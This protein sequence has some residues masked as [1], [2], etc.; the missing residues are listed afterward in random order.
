MYGASYDLT[1]PLSERNFVFNRVFVLGQD[2]RWRTIAQIKTT[3]WVM[4][5]GLLRGS[6]FLAATPML[7]L[8]M[9]SLD[10]QHFLIKQQI[11]YLLHPAIN[12]PKQNCQIADIGAGTW[13]IRGVSASRRPT[14]CLQY[15]VC[16]MFTPAQSV[17]S[18][19]LLRYHA[20]ALPLPGLAP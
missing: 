10:L 14:N 11:G 20:D 12:L 8:Q 2:Q 13:Y 7:R 9:Y 1:S 16:R 18:F 19:R 4:T 17:G 3:R 15:M 5:T 6:S